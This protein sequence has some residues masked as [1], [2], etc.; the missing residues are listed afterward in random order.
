MAHAPQFLKLV[1]DAKS[2]VHFRFAALDERSNVPSRRA[3][4]VDNEICVRRRDPRTSRLRALQPGSVDQRSGGRA[5]RLAHNARPD[6]GRRQ[7]Q[8]SIYRRRRAVGTSVTP[9]WGSHCHGYTA[10]RVGRFGIRQHRRYLGGRS[11]GD[12]GAVP[13]ASTRASAPFSAA[14]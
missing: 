5:Y 7:R 10:P 13:R 3:A 2:R 4:L 12:G 1:N 8:G 6:A 11:Q 14:H 9:S